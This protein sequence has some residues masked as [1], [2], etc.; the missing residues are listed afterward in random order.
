[1]HPS[2]EYV[3]DRCTRAVPAVSK[4]RLTWQDRHYDVDLCARHSREFAKVAAQWTEGTVSTSRRTSDPVVAGGYTPRQVREWA[5]RAG[6]EVPA[7]GRIPNDI[8][9]TYLDGIRTSTASRSRDPR[10]RSSRGT[11]G[12]GR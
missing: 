2:V 6:V 3:C 10:A 4:F 8:I 5:R 9:Q 1:M 11:D 12:G 7:R